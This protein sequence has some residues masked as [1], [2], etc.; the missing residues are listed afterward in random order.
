MSISMGVC[1][2][3]VVKQL[4]QYVLFLHPCIF[5]YGLYLLGR[6]ENPPLPQPPS[7]WTPD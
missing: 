6:L 3:H 2:M 5:T 1:G 7:G 4:Q